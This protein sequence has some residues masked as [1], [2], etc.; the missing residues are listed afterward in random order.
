MEFYVVLN[1]IASTSLFLLFKFFTKRNIDTRLAIVINYLTA[2]FC[3]FIY[4]NKPIIHNEPEHV[5]ISAV[6]GLLFVSVFWLMARTAQTAGIAVSSI[7]SKMSMIIPVMAGIM[8]YNEQLGLI[9]A[10]GMLLG[11]AAVYMSSIGSNQAIKVNR[12][13]PFAIMLFLGAGMIDTAIKFIQ[14]SYGNRMEINHISLLIFLFAGLWGIFFFLAGRFTILKLNLLHTV[15]GGLV[16]GVVNYI[17]IIALLKALEMPGTDSGAIF[18]LIN[19]SVVLLS[20]LL[21]WMIFGEKFNLQKKIGL[22]LAIISIAAL[23]WSV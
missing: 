14:H 22:G 17:S 11:L 15:L 7:S 2:S 4:L 3:A 21:A 5:I 6:L 20:S 19:I 9:K 13:I 18:G 23:S 12:G 8:L 10:L 16:L 1:I